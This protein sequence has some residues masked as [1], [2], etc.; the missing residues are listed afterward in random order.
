MALLVATAWRSNRIMES[1]HLSIGLIAPPWVAV[2]PPQYG[3]TEVVIDHL[4]RG[5]ADAGHSVKLFATADSTCPVEVHSIF[6]NAV[7]TTGSVLDELAQVQAAY[8]ELADCQLIHDHSLLGPLWAQTQQPVG[9]VV[10]TVHGE[11][12]PALTTLYRTISKSTAV[13][14]I[15]HHQRSTASCVP[16]SAV[17]HH[18]IDVDRFPVGRGDGGYV[19]FLGRMHPSKGVHRAIAIA[20]AA[21]KRLLIVAKMWEPLELDYFARCVEPMLGPDAMYLG[22]LGGSEK[23]NVLAGAEALVNPIRWAE[24][25][26]LVMIEALAAGTPVLTFMEGAAPEIVTNG[27][28]GFLCRDEQDMAA[29]LRQVGQLDRSACRLSAE[30]RFSTQRMVKDHLTLYNRLLEGHRRVPSPALPGRRRTSS[31]GLD[32][33]P[34]ALPRS[35]MSA[36]ST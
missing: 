25:F 28:T 19:L 29:K 21:E 33:S 14:A 23:M 6:P 27:V 5:L 8:D 22:Q 13:I 16:F 1:E 26:G 20:R 34:C 10:T 24:P 32:R 3:G 11:L 17:I 7:G 4:A 36:P 30:R 2:P 15:S 12:T 9:P 18:G 31:C 35:L